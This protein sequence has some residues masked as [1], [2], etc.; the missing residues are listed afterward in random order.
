[1]P[2][3]SQMTAP[4]NQPVQTGGET[5]AA[6][7]PQG[8][9]AATGDQ[10]VVTV[11]K[12]EFDKMQKSVRDLQSQRDRATESGRQTEAQVAYMAQEKDV[13]KWLS[14]PEVKKKFPDVEV[15]DL[16]ADQLDAEEYEKIAAQTQARID[17]AAN[18]RIADIEKASDPTISP[19]DK[20]ARLEQLKKN[21][22]SSS[23]QEMLKLEQTPVSSN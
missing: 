12:A 15:D 13:E 1:M 4:E 22:G 6:T 16:M 10:E 9:G 14:D 11:P 5:P 20:A 17:K 2:D 7:E 21:P 23:F 8:E 3:T 18:R 19:K